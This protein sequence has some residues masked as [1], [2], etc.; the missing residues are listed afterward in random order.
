MVLDYGF[1]LQAVAICLTAA[2][3]AYR[4]SSRTDLLP[5]PDDQSK[6]GQVMTLSRCVPTS[7]RCTGSAISNRLTAR[8]MPTL[9]KRMMTDLSCV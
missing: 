8:S 5:E 7:T 6:R 2:L 4:T 1:C 3:S 9:Y